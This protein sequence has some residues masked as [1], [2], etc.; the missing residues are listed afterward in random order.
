MVSRK[1]TFLYKKS[2]AHID[3]M[4]GSTSLTG[5]ICLTS[6]I[7]RSGTLSTVTIRHSHLM[8]RLKKREPIVT[9]AL[10]RIN[11]LEKQ[12]H[13]SLFKSRFSEHLLL[14]SRDILPGVWFRWPEE[15]H[16]NLGFGMWNY[17]SYRALFSVLLF[18]ILLNNNNKNIQKGTFSASKF[19]PSCVLLW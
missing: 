11:G 1:Y 10:L 2:C 18:T 5:S 6:T 19:S 14:M 8:K 4:I 13:L 17:L 15:S 12:I 16:R 9:K 3:T 7:I